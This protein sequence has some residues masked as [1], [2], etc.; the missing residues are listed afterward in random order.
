MF[1]SR[2][3]TCLPNL[4]LLP[5]HGDCWITINQRW[6]LFSFFF[7][8]SLECVLNLSVWPPGLICD[9]ESVHRM[10]GG[11]QDV[12]DDVTVHLLVYIQEYD[13]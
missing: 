1:R 9:L 6:L 7:F 5:C 10:L 8:C 12:T 2:V 11:Q 4:F 3:Q 13:T